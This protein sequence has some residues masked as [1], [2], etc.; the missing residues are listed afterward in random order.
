MVEKKTLERERDA[1]HQEEMCSIL[2]GESI[3]N[4]R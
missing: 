1:C 2:Q 3:E 4:I